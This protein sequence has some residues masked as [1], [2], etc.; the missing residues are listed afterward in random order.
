MANLLIGNIDVEASD[1]EIREFLNRYGIPA[2][3]EIKHVEGS[4]DR[5]AVLLTFNDIGPETLRKL[6]PRIHNMFWRDR[7]LSVQVVSMRKG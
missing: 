4:G 3:D 2:F 7:T 1:D 6:Q 5:P